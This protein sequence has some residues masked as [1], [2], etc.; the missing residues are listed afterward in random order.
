[1]PGSL[2]LALLLAL[3]RKR[4]KK[5]AEEAGCVGEYPGKDLP[6]HTAYVPLGLL[7][8]CRNDFLI[9]KR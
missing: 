8:L 3:A 6:D 1:M 4:K 2:N 5:L 7:A 9:F